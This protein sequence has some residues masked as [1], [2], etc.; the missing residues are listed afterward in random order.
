MH[1]YC[2]VHICLILH[3]KTFSRPKKKRKKEIPVVSERQGILL[4]GTKEEKTPGTQE[5]V[6]TRRFERLCTHCHLPPQIFDVESFFFFFTKGRRDNNNNNSN[7][8]THTNT[9]PYK[10]LKQKNKTT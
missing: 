4:K 8:H 1:P 6:A 3:E 2:C 9:I 10:Q 7:A 5:K